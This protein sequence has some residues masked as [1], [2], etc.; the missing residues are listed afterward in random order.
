MERLSL[1]QQIFQRPL[2]MWLVYDRALFLQ[3]HGYYVDLFTFCERRVTPRNLL[4][5]ARKSL[6]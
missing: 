2:E 3:Q 6:L 4:I 1:V 5:Q